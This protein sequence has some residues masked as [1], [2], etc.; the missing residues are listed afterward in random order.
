MPTSRPRSRITAWRPAVPGIAEVFHA[1]LV[2]HAYPAHT[3]DTWAVMVL[4]VGSVDFGLDRE[5]HGATAAGAVAVLPPG[6][7]HDG[8]TVTASGFRKR[9]LYLDT[10]V[11]AEPLTGAAVDHPVLADPLLRDRIHA[12]HGALRQVGDAFEA[13]SRL[14]F[15]RERLERH[16]G[17]RGKL[18]TSTSRDADKLAAQMRELLDARVVDGVTLAEAAEVLA[19]HP[20]RVL[21]SFQRAY[22]L[23][24]HTYLTGR[25]IDRA[26]RLLLAGQRPAEVATAVGFYD[27]AHLNRHFRRH[28]GTTP[29]RFA[30]PHSP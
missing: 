11:L 18:M 13:E 16:L 3:H 17:V 22:G 2:D 7:V 25:R 9:V 15:V 26:R 10:T 14:A 30:R 4:E 21:R 27:Q 28:L 5:R 20:T 8:R 12:L 24:P 23:P 29:G 1:R 6:V 19:A